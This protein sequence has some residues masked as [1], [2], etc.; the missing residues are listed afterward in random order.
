[1]QVPDDVAVTGFN[2]YPWAATTEIPLTTVAPGPWDELGARAAQ[3]VLDRIER[4]GG[5]SRREVMPVELVVRMS[6][7]GQRYTSR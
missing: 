1:L 3:L 7:I 2:N 6:T 4:P 5:P